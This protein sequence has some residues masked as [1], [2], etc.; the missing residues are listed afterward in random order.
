MQIVKVKD[1]ILTLSYDI[2]K[3]RIKGQ[4]ALTERQMK[5][6]EKINIQGHI[7]NKVIR[8]M[9]KLSD[10]GALKEISKLVHLGV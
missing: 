10:E 3:K 4:I 8:E 9:F 2:K 5:I 1:R 6:I 7:T